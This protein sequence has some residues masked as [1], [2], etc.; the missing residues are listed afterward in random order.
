MRDFPLQRKK[1]DMEDTSH[2]LYWEHTYHYLIPT[3][4]AAALFAF[5]NC[6]SF[7]Y[8]DNLTSI[9]VEAHGKSFS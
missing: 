7:S 2:L 9:Q 5:L 8:G 1:D 4:C 6:L 3:F